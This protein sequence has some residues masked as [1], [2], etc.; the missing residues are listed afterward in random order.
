M[1]PS[2]VCRRNGLVSCA[3]G[4]FR[5]VGTGLGMQTI[6]ILSAETT[7]LIFQQS[8]TVSVYSLFIQNTQQCRRPCSDFMD[9]LRRL[10][11]WRIIIKRKP[12]KKHKN[13]SNSNTKENK[14]RTKKNYLNSYKHLK[15][16]LS[17]LRSWCW[18]NVVI[19]NGYPLDDVSNSN[20]WLKTLP[21]LQH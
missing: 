9:M 1:T 20:T 6:I 11:S 7:V 17:R 13:N 15:T 8:G 5:H 21:S 18:Y 10:I 16:N 2:N 14:E 12:P 4:V 19:Q 3:T